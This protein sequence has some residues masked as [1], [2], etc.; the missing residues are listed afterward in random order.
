MHSTLK[1]MFDAQDVNGHSDSENVANSRHLVVAVDTANTA[2]L[3]VKIKGSISDALPDFTAAASPTNQWAY[4]QLKDLNDGSTIGGSTGVT[5]T[6]ADIH[7]MFEVN[8]NGVRHVCA[9][10]SG[11]SGGDATVLLRAFNEAS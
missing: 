8:T 5:A 4:L 2:T 11:H 1:K 10:V 7:K 9:E 3:V 6:G